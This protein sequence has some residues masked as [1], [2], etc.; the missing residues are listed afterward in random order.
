MYEEDEALPDTS[1]VSMSQL[2]WLEVGTSKVKDAHDAAK[3]IYDLCPRLPDVH[4]HLQASKS[5]RFK[6]RAVNRALAL[7]RHK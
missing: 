2:E 6:W 5:L 7:L 3:F 1:G 4:Y